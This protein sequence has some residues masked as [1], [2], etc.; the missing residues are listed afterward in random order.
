MKKFLRTFRNNY[1]YQKFHAEHNCQPVN[2]KSRK[3][4][5]WDTSKWVE[6]VQEFIDK[7]EIN[8]PATQFLSDPDEAVVCVLV[9]VRSTMA[10]YLAPLSKKK[11]GDYYIKTS[12][13]LNFTTGAYRKYSEMF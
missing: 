10:N 11:N 5:Q 2:N 3:C 7:Y 6:K 1:F 13:K 12:S 8:G 9:L 4:D